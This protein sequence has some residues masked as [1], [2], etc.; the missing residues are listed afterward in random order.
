MGSSF[1]TGGNGVAER[2]SQLGKS[3]SLETKN[4]NPNQNIMKIQTS[5]LLLLI[6]VGTTTT[7]LAQQPDRRPAGIPSSRS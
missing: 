4:L 1:M 5:L 3:A 2:E 6:G 7:T